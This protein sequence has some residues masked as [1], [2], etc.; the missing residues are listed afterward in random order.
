MAEY[1]LCKEEPRECCGVECMACR[2]GNKKLEGK[3]PGKNPY[4][5]RCHSSAG[6]PTC[7][8]P[9]PKQLCCIPLTSGAKLTM[10]WPGKAELESNKSKNERITQE[11]PYN[12]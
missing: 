10:F 1:K 4:Q 6:L 11:E 5:D 2:N 7:S 3:E 8:L 12:N 9:F